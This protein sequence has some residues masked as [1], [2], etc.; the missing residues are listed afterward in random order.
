MAQKGCLMANIAVLDHKSFDEASTTVQIQ[1]KT[2][3]DFLD[4]TLE[5]EIELKKMLRSFNRG[6]YN[7]LR[8][9]F[10]LVTSTD[11]IESFINDNG[12]TKAELESYIN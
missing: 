4:S 12:L 2:G 8:R 7:D 1:K 11:F 3:Q 10:E 5:L 9:K 6:I